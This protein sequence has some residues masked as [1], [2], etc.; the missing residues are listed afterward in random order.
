MA[1]A[2]SDLTARP[3]E[4]PQSLASL[5]AW[6]ACVAGA[7]PLDEIAATLA[8]AGLEIEQAETHD[9][10][11]VA[12]FDRIEARLQVAKLLADDVAAA[13]SELL[14]EV[15]AALERGALG[16]GVVIARRR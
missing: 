13:A 4:L 5:P 7:G 10:A 16:Y 1:S 6:V 8:H 11:L 14:R 9:D 15:R 3:G 12:L 2:L